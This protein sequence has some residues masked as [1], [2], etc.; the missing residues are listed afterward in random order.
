LT[1]SASKR[2]SIL[3]AL[4]IPALAAV[5][6]LAS[7][8]SAPP[9]AGGGADGGAGTDA[10]DA[11]NSLPCFAC[12]DAS[13]DGPL[14]VRVKGQLDQVCGSPDGCHGASAGGMSV[15]IG[16]EFIDMIDVASSEDPSLKRVAPGDP[17]HSYVYLKLACQGGI[18]DACMPLGNSPQPA[19]VALF[20]AW[21]EAGAPTQ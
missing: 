12:A 18:V 21:I 6:A 2:R 14:Y 8:S 11:G 9:D 1:A 10:A 16:R 20:R 15:V 4:A 17:D 3:P 13:F 5:A 19:V 7:C